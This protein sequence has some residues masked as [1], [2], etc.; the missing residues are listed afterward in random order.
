MARIDGIFNAI[1]ENSTT[2]TNVVTVYAC[3]KMLEIPWQQS[4]FVP[5]HRTENRIKMQQESVDVMEDTVAFLRDKVAAVDHTSEDLAKRV[6]ALDD[7]AANNHAKLLQLRATVDS[8]DSDYHSTFQSHANTHHQL[9]AQL[10]DVH[11]ALSSHKDATASSAVVAELQWKVG[12]V[13][14]RV[15]AATGRLDA[16]D[17]TVA[18]LATRLGDVS[19]VVATHETRLDVLTNHQMKAQ[20][21]HLKLDAAVSGMEK[22]LRLRLDDADKAFDALNNESGEVQWAQGETNKMVA[23]E[24]KELARSVHAVRGEVRD[25]AS[26]LPKFHVGVQLELVTRTNAVRL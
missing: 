20:A 2:I 13:A 14:T 17:A 1:H 12:D 11:E 3:F 5:V 8:R 16:V 15:D 23:V 10:G 21:L 26:D 18:D 6:R 4:R 25:V 9:Q 22:E 24:C 19:N 7:A